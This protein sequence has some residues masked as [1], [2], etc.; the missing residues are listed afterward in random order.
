M[1][2]PN[3]RNSFFLVFVSSTFQVPNIV[4]RFLQEQRNIFFIQEI[5]LKKNLWEMLAR[6]GGKFLSFFNNDFT[7]K[8]LS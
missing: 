3:I 4:M 6:Y 8:H 2:E 7:F 5:N 1:M